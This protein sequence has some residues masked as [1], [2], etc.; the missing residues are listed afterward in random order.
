MKKT[1][2]SIILILILCLTCAANTE[3]LGAK[4]DVYK[5]NQDI[6]AKE[7]EL[8][9]EVPPVL[10]AKKI[11]PSSLLSSKNHVVLDEVYND[12]F[13]NHY[14]IKTKWGYFY[15]GGDEKLKIRVN[16]IYAIDALKQIETDDVLIDGVK[17]GGKKILMAPVKAVES[18]GDAIMNPEDTLEKVQSIPTGVVDFF[19]GVAHKI[20]GE[21][22]H[23]SNQVDKI[24]KNDR[25]NGR[26]ETST[27]QIVAEKSGERVFNEGL[28]YAK[29]WIGYNKNVRD[30]EKQFGILP[31]TDN[32][33]LQDEITRIAG[34]KTGVLVSTKF[35]PGIHMFNLI[36]DAT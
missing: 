2:N 22:N 17:T 26:E 13:Y 29:R 3:F 21:I 11:V 19:S 7:K 10:S 15:A 6:I 32:E 18:V 5:P 35:V 14:T 36:S 25:E 8:G 12:G 1:N 23:V 31:D 16:E 30:L 34:I 27:A 4:G 9:Y 20:K 33:L 28:S 24:Q